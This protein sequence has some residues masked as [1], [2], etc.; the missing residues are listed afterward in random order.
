MSVSPTPT[1]V[2]NTTTAC[3][4]IAGSDVT[5][6]DVVKTYAHLKSERPTWVY[7]APELQPKEWKGWYN[8]PMVRLIKALYGQPSQMPTGRS[9]KHPGNGFNATPVE[10][11]P[12]TYWM[13][14]M[15]LMVTV[16]VDDLLLVGPLE[17]HAA[18]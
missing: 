5:Y 7:L 14:E 18:F 17:H 8:K 11:H 9:T 10:A 6:P 15:G 2:V 4:M 1:Q 13:S 16:H 3:G 12:S